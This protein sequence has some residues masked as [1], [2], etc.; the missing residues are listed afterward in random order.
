MRR[1]P[2]VS[3]F[4]GLVMAWL[5][6]GLSAC[7]SHHAQYSGAASVKRNT[8][9]LVRMTHDVRLELDGTALPDSEQARLTAFLDS[10]AFGYGDELAIDPG[11]GP[12]ANARQDA[13]ATYLQTEGVAVQASSTL[14]GGPLD[15]GMARVVVGRYVVTSP[16][17]PDW[18]KRAEQDFQNTASSN[19]GCAN[20]SNLGLMIANP[21][22][23][24]RGRGDVSPDTDVAARAVRDYRT[25]K[26]EEIKSSGTSQGGSQGGNQ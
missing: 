25:G 15:L 7:S 26:V 13:V 22:D 11:D 6:I 3:I 14:Y 23:L 20:T 12:G 8:V 5:A 2:M 19:F 21:R 24:L 10:I 4:P 16:R 18:S 17:C 9:E 1:T